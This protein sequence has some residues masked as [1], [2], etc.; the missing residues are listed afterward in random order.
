MIIDGKE[1]TEFIA[2]YKSNKKEEDKLIT[3]IYEATYYTYHVIIFNFGI[4]NSRSL[5]F[6]FA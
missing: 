6:N 1:K 2:C 5:V 4:L 3:I